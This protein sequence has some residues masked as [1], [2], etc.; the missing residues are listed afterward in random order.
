MLSISYVGFLAALN[1]T[2]E[3]LL[4][5]GATEGAWNLGTCLEIGSNQAWT[6]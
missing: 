5:E 6:T 2:H 4:V 1:E 3:R